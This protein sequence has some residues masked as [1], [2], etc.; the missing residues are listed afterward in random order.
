[1]EY[2]R[3]N[4][5]KAA[6]VSAAALTTTV[7]TVGAASEP[8]AATPKPSPLE[9]PTAMTKETSTF[10]VNGKNYP[11]EYEGAHHPLGSNRGEAG[12]DWDESQLQSRELWCV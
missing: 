5:M 11:A 3:R 1:M 9:I 2:S 4:F 10:N 6:G 7:S 8:V 12:F